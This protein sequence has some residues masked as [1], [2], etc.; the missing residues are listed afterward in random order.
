[1]TVFLLI[2]AFIWPDLKVKLLNGLLQFRGE[3]SN[4]AVTDDYME[5]TKLDSAVINAFRLSNTI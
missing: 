2:L 5:D 1:M 4:G 3:V